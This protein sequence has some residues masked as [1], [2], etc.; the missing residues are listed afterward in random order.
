MFSEFSD[1]KVLWK[2]DSDNVTM[3]NNVL[4]RKWLPQNDI[5]AHPNVKLFISHGGLFGSQEAVHHGV[6]VLGIPFYTDH[7]INLNRAQAK[8]YALKVNFNNITV[9]SLRWALSELLYNPSYSKNVKELSRIFRERPQSPMETA[10]FWIE[11]VIKFRGAVHLRSAALDLN[12]YSNF[13]LDVIGAV[14]V[15][16]IVLSVCLWVDIRKILLT[17]K[18]THG[19]K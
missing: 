9:E 2:W 7:H 8:G 6:P 5:L 3:P 11:Y 10:I 12:W 17:L 19:C 4:T 1:I 15:A 13:L 16:A 18:I 14:I